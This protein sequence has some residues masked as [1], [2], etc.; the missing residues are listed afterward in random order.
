MKIAKGSP[1]DR[2]QKAIDEFDAAARVFFDDVPERSMHKVLLASLDAHNA[3]HNLPGKIANGETAFCENCRYW[4]LD[5][6]QAL[7]LSPAARLPRVCAVPDP[8]I[9]PCVNSVGIGGECD[10]DFI[11]PAFLRRQAD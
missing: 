5:S 3:L 4:H 6:Q 1:A 2:L 7:P 10:P 9:C 11:V 8:L